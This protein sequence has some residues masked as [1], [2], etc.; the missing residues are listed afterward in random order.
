MKL[1]TTLD[2]IKSS[3][4]ISY[5]SPVMMVGS[6][7]ADEVGNMFHK[8]RIPVMINP[9][10]VLYN[11]YSVANE[12]EAIIGNREFRPEDL[13]R[14]EER[15][16]SF[17]HDTGFTSSDL[18]KGLKQI[19]STTSSA[20]QFLKSAK[21][22]F[23]TFGTARIY[24]L[25]EGGRVVANCHK[26]PA[27][28]FD[29]DLLSV[30]DI[31]ARWSKLINKIL[32]FN[33]EI[34]IYFTI[35]PVRHWKD[36]AHGNQISKSILLL[37]V[38]RLITESTFC[39]YFPS[40]ELVLDDLRDY[41]FYKEDMLHPDK[42]AVDY[43]WNYLTDTFFDSETTKI[44]NKVIKIT[45]SVSHRIIG[46]NKKE[47]KQ[48]GESMLKKIAVFKAS[49]PSIDLEREIAYFSNMKKE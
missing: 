11:P 30:D 8:G 44:Y 21:Y 10:G 25:S 27:S 34:K 9:F 26:M 40:Y 31:V 12:L 39:N 28:T 32:D 13:Y 43:I 7:F 41:R 42:V 6:C 48:F 4:R 14:F 38:E 16:L 46:D 18:E 2:P 5:S 20:N 36:G 35:S 33:S 47:Q 45:S 17:D 49:Y 29:R 3:D 22:L 37:A 1:R 19:N 23:I 15:Y 24:K